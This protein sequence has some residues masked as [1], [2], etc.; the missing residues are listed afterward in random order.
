MAAMRTQRRLAPICIPALLAV[1]LLGGCRGRPKAPALTDEG[2]FQSDEGF[3]FVVPEGWIM[4]ARGNVPPGTLDKE[5]LLVQYRRA[6][7][8]DQATLEVSAADL[9]QDTDLTAYQSGPSF[10][11]KSWKPCSQPE[12]LNI[13]GV[14]GSRSRYSG[15]INGYALDKEVTAFRRGGRVYF[16]TLL[17]SPKDATAP[18][19]AHRAIDQLVWTK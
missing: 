17:F 18:E 3:R 7:G 15:S 19:Q 13:G 4:A 5:R 6:Q 9:S 10:S 12:P 14:D 16:F 2:V 11:A 8:A 1:L